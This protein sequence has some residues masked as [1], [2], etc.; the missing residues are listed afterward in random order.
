M[1]FENVQKLLFHRF[2]G[3]LVPVPGHAVNEEFFPS[4]EM[5]SFHLVQLKTISSCPLTCYLVEEANPHLAGTSSQAV[6]ESKSI[7]PKTPLLLAKWLDSMI[8]GVFSTL[9][10]FIIL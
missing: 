2:S 8:L 10:D 4:I 6:V 9:N 7:F 3:Q 5:E 1:I